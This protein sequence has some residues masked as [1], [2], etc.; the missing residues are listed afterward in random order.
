LT[1]YLKF[2]FVVICF[3]IALV[4]YKFCV[5]RRDWLWLVTGLGFTV[6]ADYFL[7]LE[8]NHLYGVAVFCFAHVCYINRAREKASWILFAVTAVLVTVA[9]FFAS[10]I[11]LALVYAVLFCANIFVNFRF[12]K[13]E[14]TRLPKRNRTLILAGLILFALCDINVLLFNLPN[15]INAPQWFAMF[16]MLIWVFYLPSQAILAVTAYDFRAPQDRLST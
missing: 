2:A 8:N 3:L 7:V 16:F 14:K 1:F 10:V 12:F 6:G 13:D 5:S 4:T 11:A 9:L 15:Y